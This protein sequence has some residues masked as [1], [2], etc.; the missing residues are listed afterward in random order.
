[1]NKVSLDRIPSLESDQDF[2]RGTPVPSCS[3]SI[4]DLWF[5]WNR[6]LDFISGGLEISRNSPTNFFSFFSSPPFSFPLLFLFP[7]LSW[8]AAQPFLSPLLLFSPRPGPPS[9]PRPAPARQPA[10]AG[11]AAPQ[12]ANLG[13]PPAFGPT[14]R[15]SALACLPARPRS[16]GPAPRVA[17]PPAAPPPRAR[18]APLS[19]LSVAA[20]RVRPMPAPP[21][22]PRRAPR[23]VPSPLAPAPLAAPSV[24]A[25]RLGAPLPRLA[26]KPSRSPSS[27]PFATLSLSRRSPPLLAAVP[28]APEP[29]RPRRR[30]RRRLRVPFLPSPPLA[31]ARVAVARAP[32]PELGRAQRRRRRRPVA[33]RSSSRSPRRSPQPE[34]SSPTPR[35]S[36]RSAGHRKHRELPSSTRGRRRPR[37]QGIKRPRVPLLSRS[38]YLACWSAPSAPFP[39]SRVRVLP[40]ES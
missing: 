9:F 16:P 3:F 29:L 11:R 37:E 35:G 24:R 40:R 34:A 33:A 30:A 22:L 20:P 17:P 6:C 21:L 27:S 2:R 26:I 25:H 31:A 32:E 7:F 12:P 19:L 4:D 38:S 36:P 14:E 15:A 39:L 5:T 1:M 23:L 13:R 18:P 10:R 8:A 28:A